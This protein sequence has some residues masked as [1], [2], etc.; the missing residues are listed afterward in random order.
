MLYRELV[1]EC[2]GLVM[3]SITNGYPSYYLNLQKIIQ[4]AKLGE[5]HSLLRRR[6][7]VQGRNECKLSVQLHK[8][9]HRIPDVC[10]ASMPC[11]L[12]QFETLL[13]RYI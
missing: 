6:F 9:Y 10:K 4:E 8:A 7:G 12:Q 3:T 5:L 1:N 11:N 2:P 13:R